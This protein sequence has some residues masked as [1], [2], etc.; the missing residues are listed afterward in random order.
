MIKAFIFDMDG[1]IIDSEPLQL[2]SFNHV[3]Q[4]YV[5]PVIMVE[6]L[7]KYM[8]H[9]DINI[10]AKMV[11]ELNLPITKE[12][13]ISAKRAAYLEILKNDIQP[14]KGAVEAIREI[15][16]MMPVA[17]ASSSTKLEIEI[18]TKKFGIDD[19]FSVLIS[20][21]EVAQGKPAPDIYLKASELL[22][23]PPQECGAIE[24]TPLGI[25]SAKGA[26]MMYCFGITTTH[27]ADE[28]VKADKVISNFAEL[29]PAIKLLS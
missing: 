5:K 17:V 28:L 27:T 6:F 12:E 25:V 2:Q 24:D 13:F 22:G 9:Q 1:V 15:Q 7:K 23:V 20:S 3:L 8:G 14:I 16:K 10:C 21:F 18:I 11:E 29:V 26:G 19:L 4:A